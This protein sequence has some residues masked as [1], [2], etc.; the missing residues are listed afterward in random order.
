M[1][2]GDAFARMKATAL[3]I[4]ASRGPVVDEAAI[5]DALADGGEPEVSI[6][7]A[8]RTLEFAAATY[9][10]A[11]RGVRVAAGEISGDD[12]FMTRMDGDGAPWAPVKETA[13]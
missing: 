12:A 6:V 10:S 7:D 3:F 1:F 4:N 9:A 13:A 8:R 11:F 2:D 5:I